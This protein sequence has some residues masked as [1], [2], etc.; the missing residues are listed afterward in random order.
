MINRS[1]D[2]ISDSELLRQAR[3]FDLPVLTAIYDRFNNGLFYYALRLLGDVALAEDCVA[4]TFSQLLKVLRNSGGPKDNLEGYLYRCVHNWVTDYYRR[5]P[6][7]AL[8]LYSDLPDP[9]DNPSQ[10]T[11]KNI[12]CQRVRAA[13]Q[14]LTPDQCHVITLRFVEGWDVTE[15]AESLQ[16]PIGAIK[17]L[18]HRALASL[19][20]FLLEEEKV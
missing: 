8:D 19:Q 20:R 10:Q 9:E 17:S 7:L 12:V 4:E 5:K 11:E 18:Q 3:H 14:K 6:T 13:L 15:I 16:K 1:M 2:L